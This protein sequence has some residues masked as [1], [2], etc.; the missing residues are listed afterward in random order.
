MLSAAFT[1]LMVERQGGDTAVAGDAVGCC[2]GVLGCIGGLGK[3]MG[4]GEA[5]S[6]G[7]T[8]SLLAVRGTD[9][10]SVCGSSS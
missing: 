6:R 3:V 2:M 9:G 8:A 10:N 7:D 5:S 1:I 4:D